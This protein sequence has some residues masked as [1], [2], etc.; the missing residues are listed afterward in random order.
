MNITH[1]ENCCVKKGRRRKVCDTHMMTMKSMGAQSSKI[2]S[3]ATIGLC[4][5]FSKY[6]ADHSETPTN[7]KTS[8]QCTKTTANAICRPS[9]CLLTK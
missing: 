1:C 2:K 4:P 8:F 5:I 9:L 6:L 7:S 3:R